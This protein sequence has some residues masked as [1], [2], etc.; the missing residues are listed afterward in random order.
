MRLKRALPGMPLQRLALVRVLLGLHLILWTAVDIP[1]LVS[2]Y[3]SPF[4]SHGRVAT[5]VL[6]LASRDTVVAVAVTT[7]VLASVALVVGIGRRGGA[8]VAFAADSMLL[9][10]D[11]AVRSP[12][13][14]LVRLLLLVFVLLPVVEPCLWRPTTTT[15]PSAAT[16]RHLRGASLV[17]WAALAVGMVTAGISKL[18]GGDDAWLS[19]DAVGVLIEQSAWVRP[20]ARDLLMTWPAPLLAV[21]G[22]GALFLEVGAPALVLQWARWPWW[23]ASSCM[24]LCALVLFSI[25]QVSMGLLVVHLFLAVDDELLLGSR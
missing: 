23:I 14:P 18:V 22:Y 2:L 21:L 10:L 12:E 6:S 16:R 4:F 19:G 8:L 1:H 3:G 5:V 9:E 7:L 20:G 13:L 15:A 24:H 11:G 25:P 17:V